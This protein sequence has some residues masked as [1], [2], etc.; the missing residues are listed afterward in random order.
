MNRSPL[1]VEFTDLIRPAA[2]PQFGRSLD[3]SLEH[4]PHLAFGDILESRGRGG[5]VF[6]GFQGHFVGDLVVIWELV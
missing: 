6:D 4:L 5:D 3:E 2:W 1:G